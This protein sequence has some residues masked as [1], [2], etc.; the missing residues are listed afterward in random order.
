MPKLQKPRPIYRALVGGS[1]VWGRR[2]G[3]DS[4]GPMHTACPIRCH[5]AVAAGAAIVG[6]LSGCGS[7]GEAPVVSEPVTSSAAAQT[8]KTA[9]SRTD[10]AQLLSEWSDRLVACFQD[11]GVVVTPTGDGGWEIEASDELLST[12]QPQC[13]QQQVLNRRQ[14]RSAQPRLHSCMTQTSSQW[15]ACSSMVS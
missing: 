8:S 7:L 1:R 13:E 5:I 11:A 15:S 6:A 2:P 4:N 14:H 3:L 12:L 10:E 9:L